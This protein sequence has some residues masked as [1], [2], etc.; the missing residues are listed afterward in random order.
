MA[1]TQ[2]QVT[3]GRSLSARSPPQSPRVHRFSNT[4]PASVPSADHGK[5]VAIHLFGQESQ[6][7]TYAISKADLLLKGEGEEADDFKNV[8]TL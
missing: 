4:Q 2:A 6:P 3:T 8:S 1:P 7:E 5:E